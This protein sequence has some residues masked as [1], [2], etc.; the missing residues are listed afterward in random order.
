[1]GRDNMFSTTP[2]ETI[3]GNMP[4]LLTKAS[5]HANHPSQNFTPT[6][7]NISL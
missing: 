6:E 7:L 5:K 3:S 2:L 1:M 4:A